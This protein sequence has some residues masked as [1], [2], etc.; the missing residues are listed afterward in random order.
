MNNTK[1]DTT[2]LSSSTLEELPFSPSAPLS[3]CVPIPNTPIAPLSASDLEEFTFSSAS[4][5]IPSSHTPLNNPLD[6]P[7][8]TDS[9]WQF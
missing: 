8:V 9:E 4:I 5:L 2:Q 1:P 6:A 3:Q 7:A